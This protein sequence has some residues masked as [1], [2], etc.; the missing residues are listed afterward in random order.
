[1]LNHVVQMSYSLR[2]STENSDDL[3]PQWNFESYVHVRRPAFVSAIP[4]HI[5]FAFPGPYMA[6]TTSPSLE[7]IDLPLRQIFAFY[8][9]SANVLS[10]ADNTGPRHII[11]SSCVTT[12]PYLLEVSKSSLT[13]ILAHVFVHW[14]YIH[15]F[16]DVRMIITTC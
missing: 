15:S 7:D 2:D 1:M 16:V 14:K 9:T 3:P 13:R 8:P 10:G 12:C 6:L 4:F 11:I 5:L